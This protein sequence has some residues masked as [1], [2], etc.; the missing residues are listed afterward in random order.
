M[1]RLFVVGHGINVAGVFEEKNRANETARDL[2]PLEING[3]LINATVM[4]VDVSK[5]EINRE[6]NIVVELNGGN[7]YHLNSTLEDQLDLQA[8]EEAMKE[9]GIVTWDDVK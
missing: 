1:S 6:K 2:Q 9:P 8:A 3:N 7:S 4:E 5:F